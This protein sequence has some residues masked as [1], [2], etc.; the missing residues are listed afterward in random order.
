[1]QIAVLSL[2]HA[3]ESLSALVA[4]ASSAVE[5]AFGQQGCGDGERHIKYEN[6]K[7]YDVDSS[8]SD[9]LFVERIGNE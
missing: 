1:M 8:Q 9:S 3:F 4:L 7:E 5:A 6:T 2:K